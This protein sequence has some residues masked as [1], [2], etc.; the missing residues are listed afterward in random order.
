MKLL[1]KAILTTTV[2]ISSNAYAAGS[3]DWVKPATSLMESLEV[4]MVDIGAL[5]I[6]I[7]LIGVALWGAASGKLDWGKIATVVI[8]GVIITAGPAG[9]RLLLSNSA[10]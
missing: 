4:G 8:C 7:G 9:V 5:I 3:A 10:S 2:M 1:S 6:G